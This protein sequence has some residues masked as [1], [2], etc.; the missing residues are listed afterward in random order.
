[1]AM[2]VVH[3]FANTNIQLRLY[4]YFTF[5]VLAALLSV[6]MIVPGSFI[7]R[8]AFPSARGMLPDAEQTSADRQFA[9]KRVTTRENFYSRTSVT[10]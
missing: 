2:V 8:L 7:P 4:E 5:P 3:R 9:V 1:M 6:G 10:N